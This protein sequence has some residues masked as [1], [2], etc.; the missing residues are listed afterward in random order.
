MEEKFISVIA[1]ALELESGSIN[2]NDEF[3]KYENWD[4][5]AQLTLIAA[6][7]ENFGVGI[8]TDDFSKLKTLSDLLAEVQKRS[9]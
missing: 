6:L 8:E 7:D 5:L 4:S 3:R 1:D 2:L 9:A